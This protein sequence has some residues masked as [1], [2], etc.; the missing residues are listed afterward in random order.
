M[1][2]DYLDTA[3]RLL[4]GKQLY[5]TQRLDKYH[6]GILQKPTLSS[7]SQNWRR[8]DICTWS[9]GYGMLEGS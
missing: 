5:H 9:Y 8:F 6:V 7:H 4:V 1:Y 3:G 2:V